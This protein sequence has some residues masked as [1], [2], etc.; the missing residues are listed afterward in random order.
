MRYA[1]LGLLLAGC[2]ASGEDA[3]IYPGLFGQRIVGNETYVTVSNVHNDM[4]AL[5]LADGHC[6]KFGKAARFNHMEGARAVFDCVR[7]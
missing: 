7:R 2:T 1:L 5:P 4:D 6:R 3:H